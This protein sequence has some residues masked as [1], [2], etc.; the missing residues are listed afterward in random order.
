MDAFTEGDYAYQIEH[1]TA[2]VH[3]PTTI[4]ASQLAHA[5]ARFVAA[6]VEASSRLRADHPEISQT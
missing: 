2:A 1:G 5:A 6:K 3:V 4:D